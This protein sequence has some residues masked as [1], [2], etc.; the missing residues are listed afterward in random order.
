MHQAFEVGHQL[1]RVLGEPGV[2][3]VDD[4]ALLF[5]ADAARGRI[6]AAPLEFLEAA[7]K[8]TIHETISPF[9][10]RCRRAL[11][12]RRTLAA[13]G[14]P[15]NASRRADDTRAKGRAGEL[16]QSRARADQDPYTHQHAHPQPSPS[17][18][19]LGIR[20]T[21]E[22]RCSPYNS[23]DYS[24]SQ[25]VEPQIVAQQGGRVYSPY[26]GRY[27]AST[28]ETDI[29]HIVARSE[30]HDSGL[31][32]ADNANRRAFANDLLN[33]T[34]ASPS[35]NRHQKIA[36]DV[37]EWLPAMNQCW[38]VNQVVQVKRKYNLSMDQ[39]EASRVQQVLASCAS[40]TMQFTDPGA[41][42][43]APAPRPA[44]GGNA[45]EMYDSNGNGIIT[46]AEVREHGIAPVRRDHPAYQYM[47]DRDNDGTVCE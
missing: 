38:Y 9:R 41:A 22:N 12:V 11:H 1:G 20:I 3:V 7:R 26:S 16:H 6:A 24:Y 31:C 33:L 39:A 45:L 25:S 32:A 18:D 23:D 42:D 46:C 2:G 4:S 27:F 34:L 19:G 29:E 8:Q 5:L 37:A 30:A 14:V 47:N 35:V 13:G 10:R 43:P 21:P 40:T 44:Q 17:R 15:D 36:K 28:G